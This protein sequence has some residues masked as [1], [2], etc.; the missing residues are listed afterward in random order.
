MGH[1]GLT[2][3]SV[4]AFGG[5]KVQARGE[6]D[7]ERLLREAQAAR[8][9]GCFALVLEGIPARLGADG[10]RASCAIPTIGIGAGVR[11]RRPGAGDATTCSASSS[12]IS[13]SSCAATPNW[14]TATRD[15]VRALRRRR[16]GAALPERRGVVLSAQRR[17]AR[18]DAHAPRAHA[19]PTL[20]ARARARWRRAGER[21]AFVPTMGAHPRRPPVARARARAARADRVVASIFVN[22]LQFGPREDFRRYPRPARA[23]PRAAAPRPAWTCCGSRRVADVYPRG[24]RARACASSG[25]ERR[26]R[27]RLAARALRRRGHRGAA[28][29]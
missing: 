6:A 13:R 9:G 25:L 17:A 18:R 19:S 27:G 4:L 7:Q 1:L 16:E 2:P 12:A 29:C 11:M 8:G 14:A 5:Y 24:R 22:P 10:R 28:S 23:R 3:Q 21:I 15:G 20:R 26:A